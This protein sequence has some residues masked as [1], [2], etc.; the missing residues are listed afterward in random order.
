MRK[1]KEFAFLAAATGILCLAHLPANA[2]L[3]QGLMWAATPAQASNITPATFAAL[4]SPDAEFE[5]VIPDDML[6]LDFDLQ[7][8]SSS[9]TRQQWLEAGQATNLVEHTTG[10][11]SAMMDNTVLELTGTIT[12]ASGDEFILTHDDGLWQTINGTKI[13]TLPS[14]TV[15]S[16]DTGIYLGPSGSAPVTLF[17]G[18]CCEGAAILTAAQFRVPEPASLALLGTALIGFAPMLR[19]RHKTV[20]PGK[21]CRAGGK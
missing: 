9:F 17:Y 16:S 10:F 4:G 11:L 1:S 20:Q 6:T 21:T 2:A 3:L 14:P 19:R 18:E 8:D 12:V 5:I 7:G 15:P 13:I